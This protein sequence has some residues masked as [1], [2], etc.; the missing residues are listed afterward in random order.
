MLTKLFSPIIWWPLYHSCVLS[1]QVVGNVQVFG[2]LNKLESSNWKLWTKQNCMK[3]KK[4]QEH[5]AESDPNPLYL[6]CHLFHKSDPYFLSNKAC[7][8]HIFACTL[9]MCLTCS[10]IGF[11]LIYWISVTLWIFCC[12]LHMTFKQNVTVCSCCKF[13]ADDWSYSS[14]E[15]VPAIIYQQSNQMKV[16]LLGY[17]TVTEESLLKCQAAFTMQEWIS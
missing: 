17:S 12:S 3:T 11:F 15:H 16:I 13:I 1:I 4:T 9:S 2:E 8:I 6:L 14:M 7:L 5:P 10:G